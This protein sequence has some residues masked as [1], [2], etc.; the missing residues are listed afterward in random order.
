MTNATTLHANLVK[1]I[2]KAIASA[3]P[4]VIAQEFDAGAARSLHNP[5]VTFQY[6]NPG[7]PDIGIISWGAIWI[8]F[9]VKTGKATLSKLQKNFQRR[10]TDVD[11]KMFE[12]R[13]VDEAIQILG[14][15]Y[16]EFLAK[17]RM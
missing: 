4:D 14:E 6:G 10:V 8:G 16:N 9:E 17:K 2:L 7:F 15:Y 3:Y 13:S 11:A 12:I 5:D 1:Q